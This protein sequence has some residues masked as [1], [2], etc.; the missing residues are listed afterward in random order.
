MRRQDSLEKTGMLGKVDGNRKRKR[1]T[2]YKKEATGLRLQKQSRA[3][4]DRTFW[5][6]LIHMV[7]IKWRRLDS[8]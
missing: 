6:S 3:V 5:R 2:K 1:K 4:E 8:T 7:A